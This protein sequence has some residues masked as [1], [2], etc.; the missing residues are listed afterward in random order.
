MLSRTLHWITLNYPTFLFLFIQSLSFLCFELHSISHSLNQHLFLYVKK[1]KINLPV[2]YMQ[3][4]PSKFLKK[5]NLILYKHL[6]KSKS[7]DAQWGCSQ[8]IIKYKMFSSYCGIKYLHS[9]IYSDGC[10]HYTVNSNTD[11]SH[12]TFLCS[13]HNAIKLSLVLH[14]G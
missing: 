7:L 1:I 14:E 11:P 6:K 9:E 5:Q 8:L 4:Q 2:R 10:K 3:F 13:R 12:N